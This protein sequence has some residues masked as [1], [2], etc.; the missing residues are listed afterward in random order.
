[1]KVSHKSGTLVEWCSSEVILSSFFFIEHI[2]WNYIQQSSSSH[3][4]KSTWKEENQLVGIWTEAKRKEL[5]FT[6]G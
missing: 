2:S 4:S 1:M 3:Q 5:C 6:C